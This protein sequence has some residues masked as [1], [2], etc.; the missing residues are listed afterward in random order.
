MGFINVTCTCGYT[1]DL[2]DFCRTPVYGELPQGHFQCPGCKI[3]WQRKE[4]EH[5]ILRH[6]SA[7]TII[8]GKVEMVPVAG[9]L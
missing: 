8:P 9:R 1:G 7:A 5:R 4:S 2:A 6:G 3:A